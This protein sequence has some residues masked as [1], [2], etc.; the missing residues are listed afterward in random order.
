MF[1]TFQNHR[2]VH[3]ND[4]P[5]HSR[6]GSLFSH[7]NLK[8]QNAHN[9][10]LCFL[11][12]SKNAAGSA[13]LLGPPLSL[14]VLPTPRPIST[15][16]DCVT[17]RERRG[18]KSWAFFKRSFSL[19]KSWQRRKFSLLKFSVSNSSTLMIEIRFLI[20]ASGASFTCTAVFVFFLSRF[21][22]HGPGRDASMRFVGE[23]YGTSYSHSTAIC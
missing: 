4:N 22:R 1:Q 2:D 5:D 3:W 11:A 14:G 23:G 10:P 6:S 12:A 13:P 15:I 17:W 8:N 7:G 19:D 9:F 20:S 18:W 21:G 16:W